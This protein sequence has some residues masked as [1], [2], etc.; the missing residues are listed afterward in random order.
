[1]AKKKAKLNPSAD[2]WEIILDRNFRED[3]QYWVRQDR[4]L[5]LRLLALVDAI[6]T[7]PFA[8]I[9][10]PELLKHFRPNLWS[11]RLTQEHRV[12]YLV[13]DRKVYLLGARY[14]Y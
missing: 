6:A 8:G 5:T 7:D 14:H 1:M 2:T 9:G 11:R 10:K 12:V 3:L 4:K 13:G